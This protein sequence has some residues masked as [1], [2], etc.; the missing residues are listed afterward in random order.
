MRVGLL[1]RF[2]G[3]LG[4]IIGPLLVLFPSP[5]VDPILCF[6]LLALASLFLGYWPRG[7]PPA[8][9]TG[10]AVPWPSRAEVLQD[11]AGQTGSPNGEVEAVG[12][13]VRRPEEGEQTPTGARRPR[14]KRKRRQ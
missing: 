9:T 2:M 13:G 4:A 11:V 5:L 8:W 6:W 7:V 3:V 10:E 1:T 14:R 12:Q